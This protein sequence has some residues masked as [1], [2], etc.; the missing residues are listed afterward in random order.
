MSLTYCAASMIWRLRRNAPNTDWETGIWEQ[1]GSR[2]SLYGNAVIHLE[3]GSVGKKQL[4]L[5]MKSFVGFIN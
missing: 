4:M 1:V 3:D 2:S 5:N